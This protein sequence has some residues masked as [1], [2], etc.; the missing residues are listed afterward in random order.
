[1]STH[2]L[3]LLL[4]VGAVVLLVSIAAV[5]LAV[6]SGLPTLLLYL[7]LGLVMGENVLGL[8]F[9]DA[10]LARS[11]GYAALVVILAEGGL[12]TSFGSIRGAVPAAAS[13]A[14]I[15]TAVSV[16]VVGVSAHY[17]LD[18]GWQDALLIGAVLAPTDSA[19]VFSVLRKV[20]LPPRLGGLLEA[21]SGF[22]DAPVVILVVAL[23]GHDVPSWWE[24]LLLLVYELVLGGVIG[25]AVGYAGAW[26]VRRIALPS[27][28]LYPLAV[29]A[30]CVTAYG[31]AA[32][33]HAS[34]FLAVYLAALVL[35]NV[36]LP[37][38][39][40]TRGFVEGA[41]WLAQIGLF[42]MLGLLATPAELGPSLLPALGVGLVLLLLARP[43]SVLGALAPFHWL[44]RRLP[45]WWR[46]P[47]NRRERV[48]LSWA[49]LRGAVP[50]VLA[51]VPADQDVFN[52]VFVLVVMFTLLQA[53]T[54]PWVARRLGVVAEGEAQQLDI[55]SS[56][57]TRLDA[58]LLQVRVT[59]GSR[60][61]GVEVVELQLPAGAAVTLVVRGERAFVPGPSTPIQ[62][63]DDLLLV[64][65]ESVRNEVER[66][67]RAVSRGGRLADW[68]APVRRPRR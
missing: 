61:A 62:V 58:D 4:L 53:P 7:G 30:L 24:L 17:L 35:G 44:P 65:T 45:D 39:S 27:S 52:L 5:R 49:G 54:L 40:A 12:T 38:R 51:T 15:G 3:D 37:H 50:V 57:L 32:V 33:A 46:F 6:G 67:L 42:V 64:T 41:G 43:L 34:G 14:T 26:G 16:V 68:K 9:D 47:T 21:E 18:V 13:L 60:L 2:E 10:S 59:D 8:D 56:P 31:A 48:L 1:V 55:E 29:M 66:R 20:P 36:R 19:A 22:N 23:A 63:G 28:G 25:I 11:L